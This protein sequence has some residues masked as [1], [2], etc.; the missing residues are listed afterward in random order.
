M[1]F[2]LKLSSIFALVLLAFILVLVQFFTIQ[3][4]NFVSNRNS[5]TPI[6]LLN[7]N[8]LEACSPFSATLNTI[9]T[10]FSNNILNLS[11]HQGL[12]SSLL[13]QHL[14]IPLTIISF[15]SG[16]YYGIAVFSIISTLA[17]YLILKPKKWLLLL[18]MQLV[19]LF[20][21]IGFEFTNLNT[22]TNIFVKNYMEAIVIV[23]MLLYT[24]IVLYNIQ[25]YSIKRIILK[26]ERKIYVTASIVGLFAFAIKHLHNSKF[27]VIVHLL[28]FSLL[29]LIQYLVYNLKRENRN[30]TYLL[31]SVVFTLFF[32]LCFMSINAE[33]DILLAPNELTALK[34][35]C[36]GIFSFGIVTNYT[37]L[38]KR[39]KQNKANEVYISQYVMLLKNY[40]KLLVEEK[41]TQQITERKK[42]RITLKE[43]IDNLCEHL[44]NEHKLT[45]REIEVLY[46][47]WDGKTNKDIASALNITLSTTKYHI[48]NIYIKLN[49]NSRAQVFA[50]KEW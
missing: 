7:F 26:Y 16:A 8:M 42:E 6:L 36:I 39:E 2:K 33:L 17:V 46:L 37:F 13:V 12:L 43:H 44:K 32:G 41:N 38:L 28:T 45:D 18:V 1:K 19:I 21:F 29:I 3:S 9:F 48:S 10:L 22:L 49:V 27:A 47:I 25:P 30:K 14:Q 50:L 35:I 11:F 24:L 34:L 20:A 4:T 23:G 5:T 15:I 31:L 40:H